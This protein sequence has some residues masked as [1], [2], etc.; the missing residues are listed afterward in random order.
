MQM[1][2]NLSRRELQIAVFLVFE[3]HKVLFAHRFLGNDLILA[4]DRTILDIVKLIELSCDII[5]PNI[6]VISFFE[7]S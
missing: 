2:F 4:H 7:P 1:F 3:G 6:S 5:V